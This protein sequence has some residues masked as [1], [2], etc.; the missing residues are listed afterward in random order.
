MSE[1]EFD[2]LRGYAGKGRPVV[3]DLAAE[4]ARLSAELAALREAMGQLVASAHQQYDRTDMTVAQ[5]RA[6]VAAF[7]RA[8]EVVK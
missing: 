8:G 3:V 2:E 4:N 5:L 1:N 7:D 6:A